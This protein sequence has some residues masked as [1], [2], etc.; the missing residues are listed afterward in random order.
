MENE[1]DLEVADAK[2]YMNK[3]VPQSEFEIANSTLQILEEI[4]K[5]AKSIS[6]LK[7]EMVRD[8]YNE[9]RI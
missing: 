9:C 5:N 3:P 2:E 8:I 7:T 6:D 1:D 4:T